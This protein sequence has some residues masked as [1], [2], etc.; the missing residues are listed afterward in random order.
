MENIFLKLRQIIIDKMLNRIL[1]MLPLILLVNLSSMAQ[2][3]KQDPV[4]FTVENTPVH[5]SEFNYIYTKTNGDNADFSKKSLDEYLDLYVKFKLKVQRAKDMKLDTIPALQQELEGYRKQ[6]ANSYLVDKEVTER[7]TRETYDRSLKDVNVS[8]VMIALAPTATPKDTA[9]AFQKMKMIKNKLDGGANFAAVAKESSDDQSAKQNGGNIGFLTAMLPNG[10]YNL[11]SAAYNTSVGEISNIIRT[12][13]GY[14]V[15]RNE[16]VREARGEIVAAHILIRKA[17]EDKGVA[18]KAKIEEIYKLLEGGESFE[19][20][21]RTNSEDKLSSSKGGNLGSF[22]I[23]KYERSFEDAAFGIEKEGNYSKPIETSIG[24]HILKLISRKPVEEYDVAKRKLAQKIQRDSRY[25]IAQDAMVSRIKKDAGFKSNAAVL[26][27]FAASAGDQFTTH[28]WKPATVKSAE[29]IFSFADG[30]KYTLADFESFCQK[31][32]RDRMRLARG[33]TT[34]DAV[35]HLYGDFVKES[36]MAY[37]ERQLESKYPEFKSLMRE[38]EEGILLFEATKILVWDKASQDS[39][40]LA[41]YYKEYNDNRKY[42]WKERAE[43][44]FYALKKGQESVLS[45]LRKYAAK[46]NPKKVLSKYNKKGKFLTQRKEMYEKGKNKVL[47]KLEWKV[48][49]VSPIEINKKDGSSNFMKI[50]KVIP[51]TPK[52]LQEAR[53]YVVADYQDHLER[54]WVEELRKTYKVE[55]NQKVFDSMVK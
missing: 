15:I 41:A 30:T 18:A 42:M 16:G 35:N 46:S 45:K 39:V 4:L 33:G 28:R 55:I 13:A 36:C 3:A 34:E 51:S 14:H 52:T 1:L 21:A 27:K 50:E 26:K 9:V 20:L 5:K 8:H 23:N 44:S 25:T 49:N 12:A 53:G 11:E 24:W 31:K 6:L 10:F 37:E 19:A 7:L 48:G 38:Y 22:G 17:K 2:V 43:V 29:T 32:S 40:G 47:D 54:E